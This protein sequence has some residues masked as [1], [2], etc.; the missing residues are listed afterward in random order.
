MDMAIPPDKPYLSN[1]RIVRY[2]KVHFDGEMRLAEEIAYDV[3][4]EQMAK[5]AP[6]DFALIIAQMK[7]TEAEKREALEWANQLR[8]E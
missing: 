8:A 7:W 5:L 3:N 1:P 6:D 2:E 4:I